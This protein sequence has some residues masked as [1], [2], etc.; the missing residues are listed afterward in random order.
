[1]NLILITLGLTFL[2]SALCIVAVILNWFVSA[3]PMFTAA[4]LLIPVTIAALPL[5]FQSRRK[6]MVG[7]A[8]LAALLLFVWVA[9]T[10]F[11]VGMFYLPATAMMAIAA[12]RM[13]A[14]T[15][16]IPR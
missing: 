6:V 12:V 1:M 14:K 5:L 4:M 8:Y 10:G 16:V 9:I 11:S 15:P 7:A 2:T 13:A 3:R